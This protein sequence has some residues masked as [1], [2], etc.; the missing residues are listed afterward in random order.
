VEIELGTLPVGAQRIPVPLA[1]LA[2]DDDLRCSELAVDNV[3]C[4]DR[5]TCHL[6]ARMPDTSGIYMDVWRRMVVEVAQSP[7]R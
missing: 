2:K 6:D 7:S 5:D 3:A 4:I 1:P